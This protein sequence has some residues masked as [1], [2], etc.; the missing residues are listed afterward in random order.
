MGDQISDMEEE[1]VSLPGTEQ[2]GLGFVDAGLDTMDAGFTSLVDNVKYFVPRSYPFITLT[3]Q[4]GAPYTSLAAQPA[5]TGYDEATGYIGNE[6]TEGGVQTP[7]AKF[8]FLK[9]SSTV[10]EMIAQQTESVISCATAKMRYVGNIAA[11]T[12]AGVYTTKINYLA[13]P[14]Y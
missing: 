1:T 6:I 13:A 7:T 9:T 11:D 4:T 2:F 10:P 8:K 14:Q 3:S 12:P 5:S